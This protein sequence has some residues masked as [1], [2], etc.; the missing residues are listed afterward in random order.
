[1]NSFHPGSVKS[2]NAFALQ[3]RAFA[4]FESILLAILDTGTG[5]W[6]S[7]VRPNLCT[8]LSDYTAGPE[9]KVLKVETTMGKR[10]RE[11]THNQKDG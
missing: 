2:A 5:Q 10:K 6:A 8:V 4:R 9:G 11:L 3:E 1:M 7:L